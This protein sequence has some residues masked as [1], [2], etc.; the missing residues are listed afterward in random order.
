[1]SGQNYNTPASVS[2]KRTY[3]DGFSGS[4]PLS[5]D[6]TYN[7]AN[8]RQQQSGESNSRRED[9][10]ISWDMPVESRADSS[11]HFDSS[12]SSSHD[13]FHIGSSHNQR[14]IGHRPLEGQDTRRYEHRHGNGKDRNSRHFDGNHRRSDKYPSNEEDSR[15]DRR[16]RN[17]QYGRNNRDD[18][19]ERNDRRDRNDRNDQHDRKSRSDWNDRSDRGNAQHG[20]DQSND[21]RTAY[22]RWN[23]NGH[24]NN[25]SSNQNH[26]TNK[27]QRGN[28]HTSSTSLY[29]SFFQYRAHWTWHVLSA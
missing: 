10:K 17:D 13:R 9:E 27:R 18:R 23:Q 8:F 24:R 22:D 7:S 16:D 11:H 4:H 29:V 1:M 25:K 3:S 19:S 15:S 21:N 6:Y 20:R 26:N 12:N 5:S 28:T 2:S 14:A